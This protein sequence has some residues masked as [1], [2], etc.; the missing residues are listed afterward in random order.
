VNVTQEHPGEHH[1]ADVRAAAA[2]CPRQAI[3][4]T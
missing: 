3:S 1:H 4:V 2:A